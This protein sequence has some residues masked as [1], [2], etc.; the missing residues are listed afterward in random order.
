ML[1]KIIFVQSVFFFLVIAAAY[2]QGVV[3]L[4]KTTFPVKSLSEK[5]IQNQQEFSHTDTSNDTVNLVEKPRTNCLNPSSETYKNKYRLISTYI[6]EAD[7]TV[8]FVNVNFNIFQDFKGKNNFSPFTNPQDP[9]RLLRM[10]SWI[11]EIYAKQPFCSESQSY[12][13]DPPVGVTVKDLNK[14]FI[15]FKLN[16][17]YEYKDRTPDEG[18]WKSNDSRLLLKRISET[19]SNRLEQL[20][21]CFTEKFFLGSVRDIIIEKT[22]K[23]YAH[24]EVIIKSQNGSGAKAFANVT[25]GFIKSVDIVAQGSNYDENTKVIIKGGGGT[26]AKVMASINKKTGGIERINVIEGGSN[27]N[28]TKVD[29]RGGGGA[30]ALAYI[31]E[32]KKGKLKS[33][34]LAQRGSSYIDDPEIII[35]TDSKGSGAELA[36]LVRGATGFTLTPSFQDADLFIVEKSLYN[37]GNSDGDYAAATNIAH[38]LGHVLDL[39]HTYSGANEANNPKNIDYLEDLFGAQF[40]GFHAL[41]WGKDPC[42]NTYDNITNNLMGGNQTSQYT[43]PMQIGKMHRALHIYNVN[44]YTECNCDVKKPWIISG[45][46][47]WDFNVKMYKP[48]IVKANAV[49]TV[50]CKLEMPDGCDIVIENGARLIIEQSGTITGGC[51]KAWN[52]KLLI[53]KGAEFSVKPGGKYLM[54]DLSKLVIE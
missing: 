39:L 21:I 7:D 52:G 49:L 38:E 22:G 48:V 18:F 42:I 13:S 44:K 15:Q 43:S 31:D 16:G 5:N 46:E 26:G 30:G 40:N 37:N 36:A 11:N 47:T 32:I 35:S 2:S 8:L 51:N 29:I 3:K 25:D 20:N 53:K 14:K 33:I 23:N 41:N 54:E 50:S 10:L 6:P 27:Y 19:D 1:L 12:N 34:Y 28:Y 24:P 4:N 17:I 9:L 45:N